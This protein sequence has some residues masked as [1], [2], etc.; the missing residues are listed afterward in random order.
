MGGCSQPCL[1]DLLY[2]ILYVSL[3][4]WQE[5]SWIQILAIAFSTS[6]GI[7]M[8]WLLLGR[9]ILTALVL[10]CRQPTYRSAIVPMHGK[11]SL[12]PRLSEPTHFARSC[13]QTGLYCWM[14]FKW[15]TRTQHAHAL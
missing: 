9:A 10:R 6:R 2:Q 5:L 3:E 7:L 11:S 14:S 1:L 13:M 8:C 4:T 15:T 12:S